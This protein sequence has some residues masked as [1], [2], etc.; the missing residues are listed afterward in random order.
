MKKIVSLLMVIAITFMLCAAT[1][2]DSENQYDIGVFSDISVN[3]WA[4]D[5]IERFYYSGIVSGYPDNTFKPNELI[6]RAEFAKI[7][8]NTLNE[9]FSD[10]YYGLYFDVEDDHPLVHYIY[11]AVP[12]MTSYKGTETNELLFLPDELVTREEAIKMI[13]TT[14]GVDITAPITDEL[15]DTYTD[16][17][18]ISDHIKPYII[19]AINNGIVAGYN[20]NTI[21]GGEFITRA[22]LCILLDRS[23]DYNTI[24]YIRTFDIQ[25]YVE[26]KP[27]PVIEVVTKT[28]IPTYTQEELELLAKVMYVEAGSSWITDEQQLMFGNVV[29]NRVASPEFPNTIRKVVYQPGAYCTGRYATCKPDKR[30]YRNAKKLLEGYR[31]L[32]ESVVFQANFKQG[33]S[34]YKAIK[35][36]KLG[37]TYFCHSSNMGYYI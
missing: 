19:Y 3:H 21:K 30:T 24:N 4:Y 35:I 14:I 36:A 29:L 37:T 5:T 17:N 9:P 7:F 34:V 6:T 1:S 8:V 31:I 26:P 27:E 18:D 12:Y 13:L 32:P 16:I 25:P 10:N 15:I 22:E 28:Y 20:D 23:F 33:S 2:A 11:N